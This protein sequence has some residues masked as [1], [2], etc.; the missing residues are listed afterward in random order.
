LRVGNAAVV[1]VE[2]KLS[3]Q[4][5]L[6]FSHIFRKGTLGAHSI[7]K[8][9][10]TVVTRAMGAFLLWGTERERMPME[11]RA[12]MR[13]L[14]GFNDQRNRNSRIDSTR[15]SAVRPRG[16]HLC[17]RWSAKYKYLLH[18]AASGKG[19]EQRR[20]NDQ[21]FASHRKLGDL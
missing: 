7:N 15:P 17:A 4:R 16:D 11:T 12:C 21:R 18:Y 8:T 19:D 20:H 9:E 3:T 1:V 13:L 6:D 2:Q 14:G 10:P 5:V